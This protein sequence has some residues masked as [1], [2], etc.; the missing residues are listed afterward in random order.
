LESCDPSAPPE[1]CGGPAPSSGTIVDFGRY[2]SSTLFGEPNSGDITGSLARYS[3]GSSL[4]QPTIAVSLG[5]IKITGSVSAGGTL[6][7]IFSFDRCVDASAFDGIGFLLGGSVGNASLNLTVQTNADFPINPAAKK[8]AC[9]Y[10]SCD[11]R[12]VAC[13]MPSTSI[14][15]PVS[16]E[17]VSEAWSS[18][19]GGVPESGVTPEGIG[20]LAFTV[21]CPADGGSCSVDLTLGTLRFIQL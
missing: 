1:E 10:A 21:D 16:V 14:A 8:G 12:A 2:G 15:V 5:G 9:H 19:T 4:G 6:G 13:V 3:S 17:D 11:D 18:F 20:G 7:W